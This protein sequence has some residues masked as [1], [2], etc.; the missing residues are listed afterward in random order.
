MKKEYEKV[1]IKL[2]A[3]TQIDALNAST[4]TDDWVDGIDHGSD[5]I[6]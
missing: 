3:L 5:D 2:I 4:Q 6:Y 1:H